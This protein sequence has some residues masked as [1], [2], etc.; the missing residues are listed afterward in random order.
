[1]KF[2]ILIFDDEILVC[3][4]LKRILVNDN[5][6]IITV[7]DLTSARDILKKEPID[8]VLLDYNLGDTDGLTVLK[9]VHKKYPGMLIV[10]LTAYATVDIAVSAMKYGAFDFL[11][12]GEDSDY[13]IY[14]VQRALDTMKL[15]KE[16]NELRSQCQKEANLP[17]LIYFSKKMHQVVQLY[18]DFA[19]TDTTVL[20]TGETGTGKSL[21]AKYI[22]KKSNRFHNPIITINCAAI[23][24]ELLESELFGYEEGAFTNA[25][26]KGKR[27]LIE[28]AHGGT[29][30]LD[31]IG[32][33]SLE[34][35]S[36][37]LHVLE[38]NEF[39]KVG[40]TR[41]TKVDVRIITATN[42]NLNKALD[43][44]Q[45]RTDLY[46]RLNVAE[47]KIPP[48]RDRNKDILPLAK[49][50]IEEYN[51]VFN[52]HVKGLNEDSELFLTSSLWPGNIRELKNYIE[53]KMLLVKSDILSPDEY[54]D[55]QIIRSQ[56]ELSNTGLFN[57]SLNPGP[58]INLLHLSRR[59]LIEQALDI[60]E[61][62]RSKAAK[63]LGI[64]RTS[65]NHYIKKYTIS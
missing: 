64:P 10:M 21:L 45:F 59:L 53:R 60:T 24:S 42:K 49:I 39:Y 47:I 54:Y 56:N 50:F 23:P 14:T 27:G 4:S 52:K 57:I 3:N 11:Q 38:H 5:L 32:E 29:L 25:K 20:L 30:F 26:R 8:L 19:R 31:E 9:E 28:Q 58:D 65:L 43:S 62:N 6:N 33:M 37:L 2:N 40:G 35:Q 63:L 41:P 13:I 7:S 51:Q 55:Q 44:K 34:M 48:L 46:Y 15:K 12:K 18:K 36:K 1:M 22:H 17:D 61:N 16:V